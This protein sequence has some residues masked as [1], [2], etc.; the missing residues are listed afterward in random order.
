MEKTITEILKEINEWQK[1]NPKVRSFVAIAGLEEDNIIMSMNGLKTELI[2]NVATKMI[3]E[4]EFSEII[5]EA[6]KLVM[7]YANQMEEDN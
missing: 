4:K 1:E 3:K 6:I 2:E 5:S 7:K